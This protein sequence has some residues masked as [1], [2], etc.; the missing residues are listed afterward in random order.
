MFWDVVSSIDSDVIVQKQKKSLWLQV[1]D[2]SD[3]SEE[4]KSNINSE[5]C[6][7]S[8]WQWTNPWGRLEIKQ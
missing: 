4:D 2:F 8:N 7:F 3:Y 1:Y 6:P 5:N